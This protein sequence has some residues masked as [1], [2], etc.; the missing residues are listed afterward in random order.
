MRVSSRPRQHQAC[1]GATV[2]AVKG[3]G[4]V[5]YQPRVNPR[6]WL[7]GPGRPPRRLAHIDAPPPALGERLLD[8]LPGFLAWASL[9]LVVVGA[10][11]DPWSVFGVAAIIGAYMAA[12]LALAG[13]ANLHGLRRIRAWEAIDWREEYER[14]RTSE[15]L[16]WD[17]VRHVMIIPNYREDIRVLRNTLERL[18][19]MSQAREQMI[20]VLAMEASDPS[21][22]ST[23]AILRA[24]FSASFR[25][26]LVTMH[27]RGLPGEVA[28]KSSNESWAARAAARELVSDLGYSLDHILVTIMDADS[29][30]HPRY[31]ECLT[32]LFA[33]SPDRHHQLWQAPIR[34]HGNVWDAS[35]ALNLVQV[36]SSS[37]ELAYLAG[38][39]WQGM[40]ISTYSLSLRLADDVGYWDTNVIAEDWHMFIK[41]YFHRRG[42]LRIAPVYLPFVAYPVAGS[43]FLDSC[44]NR[45]Q[46]TL[47]HA[48]GAK[49][50]GYT[51]R[52]MVAR[53]APLFRATRVFLR[54]SHDHFMAGAGW[55]IMTFGT[56]LPILLKPEL[57]ID[58]LWTP[59]FI[60][61]QISLLT[62]AFTG[63]LFWMIDMQLRPPRPRPW[64][65]RE[66]L[67]TVGSF[68]VLPALVLFLL[69]IPVIEAQTRLM[70]GFSLDYKVAR[71]V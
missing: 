38:W 50:I 11:Y 39:W 6:K 67:L 49:E 45:Y 51:L 53:P 3:G 16:A 36:Y 23:A 58:G 30:L 52:Q 19:S 69:A 37:W 59:Q 61:L 65:L 35:P 18:A 27:P 42:K 29:L 25:H 40:P 41:C 60:L 15:S 12:R 17:A 66:R 71:K 31:V 46:Q 10:I 5:D 2:G 34:Y 47:R 54:V 22:E 24:E 20:V 4:R 1:P 56:Q 55:V 57:V 48:W 8:G 21:G 9:I 28:G 14:R 44:R 13:I 63:V 43:N 26:V 7:W 68:L 33:T 32:C 64:T 70:L 62:V